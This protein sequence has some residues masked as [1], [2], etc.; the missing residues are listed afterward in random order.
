MEALKVYKPMM[1]SATGDL[2]V[3]IDPE[4]D[5]MSIGP[6][7]MKRGILGNPEVYALGRQI[8]QRPLDQLAKI[9]IVSVACCTWE[10]DRLSW[11]RYL[12]SF[13]H[14]QTLLVFSN[15]DA[16]SLCE[17]YGLCPVQSDSMIRRAR[18]RQVGTTERLPGLK[19]LL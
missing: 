6:Y 18:C 16:H 1:E 5:I 13:T 17:Y 12:G 15:H 14:L 9:K 8:V 3:Y 11:L 7:L 19:V 10:N 4:R 2:G